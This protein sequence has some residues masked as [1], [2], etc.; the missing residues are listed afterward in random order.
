[1]PKRTLRLPPLPAS[2]VVLL[3]IDFVNPLRFEGAQRLRAAAVDAALA[4]A[5]LRRRARRA[6]VQTVYANDNYGVW[7]SDFKDLWARCSASGGAAGKDAYLRG[8]EL[9]IPEDCV[10]AE[11]AEAKHQAIDQMR[12]VLKAHTQAACAPR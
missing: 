10:A 9:W 12:R 2:P 11:S 5:Q 7:R 3:L 6:N 4:T 8:Y 1:M